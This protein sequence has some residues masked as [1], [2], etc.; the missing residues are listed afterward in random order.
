MDLSGIDWQAWLQQ[1]REFALPRLVESAGQ[2]VLALV[3]LWASRWMLRRIEKRFTSRTETELDDHIVLLARRGTS[4]SIV[5]WILWRL[6][7]IWD[8]PTVAAVVGGA[9]IVALAFPISEF[10][11]NVLR[12]AEEK[13]VPRTQTI[14]DDTAL[15]LLN[16]LVRFLVVAGAVVLAL[17]RLG[18]N[19]TPLIA[20]ASVAGLAIGLA[21][22]DTLSNLIAGV[23]LIL[24]RP[25]KVGDRIEVWG[26][27]RE[28]ATWGDVIE[29]GLR[30]TQIRNTDNLIFIIPNNELMRRDIINYTASGDHIRVRISVNIAYD[31]DA[32]GS[33][34]AILKV[35]EEIDGILTSPA[36]QVIIRRFGESGVTLQLRVWIEDARMRRAIMDSI[37]DQIKAEFDRQGI[38]IPYPKRDL[39][40]KAMPPDAG[41]PKSPSATDE[42]TE[43]KDRS[44]GQRQAGEQRQAGR[45]SGNASAEGASDE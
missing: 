9:W 35:V 18:I 22:K 31:A 13:I 37:T 27:P 2:L 21:A 28:T 39:Y 20:G 4:V 6:A 10:I 45:G 12:F 14:L 5:M 26:A 41:G 16:K 30:A 17:D 38:E 1:M 8:L 24:D 44:A 40:I 32:E 23:I 11:A 43:K 25:F 36:P 29:I 42:S 7:H 34:A 3:L 33:K 15:P 19:I